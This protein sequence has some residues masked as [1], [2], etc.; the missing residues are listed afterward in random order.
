MIF[1]CNLSKTRTAEAARENPETLEIYTPRIL[2]ASYTMY[3]TCTTATPQFRL[4][5]MMNVEGEF[6]KKIN[7]KAK[8]SIG[9]IVWFLEDSNHNSLDQG[10]L[11]NPID[12]GIE[13]FEE[14]GTITHS[15]AHFD[16]TQ[17]SLRI[18][19]NPEAKYLTISQKRLSSDYICALTLPI[20]SK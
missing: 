16:S 12:R 10:F 9:D 1:G 3:D 14:D 11:S 18:R 2:F 15:L 19:M 8:A 7:E 6:K 5:K 20:N 13:S 17:I 4:L